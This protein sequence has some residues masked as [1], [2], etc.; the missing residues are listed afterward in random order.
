[1][2]GLSPLVITGLVPVIWLRE[3]LCPCKRDG[4]GQARPRRRGM[5]TPKRNGCAVGVVAPLLPAAIVFSHPNPPL[6]FSADHRALLI[7]TVC[8]RRRRLC[9]PRPDVLCAEPRPAFGGLSIDS[10]D[11]FP[12]TG[13]LEPILT[14]ALDRVQR[15]AA[16]CVARRR[17]SF[18]VHEDDDGKLV[19]RPL[20]RRAQ[21]HH[22]VARYWT[23]TLYNVDG[24]LVANPSAATASPA[25][26]AQGR[27]HGFEVVVGRAPIRA[28]GCRPAASNAMSSS[29]G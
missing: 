19:D 23:P 28:T 1:M 27:R 29:C 2:A 17:L 15:A 6:P 12:K 4:A 22:A 8:P 11:A 16:D 26:R 20:R 18:T 3:A 13:T 21:R 10:W 24:G 25:S 9:G 5:A 14:R 7:G